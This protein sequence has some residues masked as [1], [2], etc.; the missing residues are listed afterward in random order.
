MPSTQE[1]QLA[2]RRQRDAILRQQKREILN[3]H[4]FLL[5]RIATLERQVLLL[6]VENE[7]LKNA[8]KDENKPERI[9]LDEEIEEID[10]A[11]QEEI[12][13]MPELEPVVE[14]VVE[15][16]EKKKVRIAKKVLWF[17]W[18]DR[19]QTKRIFNISQSEKLE[20]EG[21]EQRAEFIYGL[22]TNFGYETKDFIQDVCPM[23]NDKKIKPKDLIKL[24]EV[25]QSYPLF[26]RECHSSD[27]LFASE[28][29]SLMKMIDKHDFQYANKNHPLLKEEFGDDFTI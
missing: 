11:L 13:N 4:P 28:W 25:E 12:L 10:H 3:Q 15:K 17:E 22:L 19:A 5:E 2:L 9:L 14:P 18:I 26:A 20:D 7:K 1:Q 29:H 21:F 24:F 27:P 6:K 8:N 16:K 23:L